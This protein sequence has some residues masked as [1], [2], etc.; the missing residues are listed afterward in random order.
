MNYKP[1]I[2]PLKS[3][4]NYCKNLLHSLTYYCAPARIVYHHLENIKIP[5]TFTT[6]RIL[7][8]LLLNFLL[9]TIINSSL[10]NPG[11]FSSGKIISSG[12]SLNVLYQMFRV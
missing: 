5:Q 3:N 2:S 6:K 4:L 11:P 8:I 12:L 7:F 10:L 9:I 1:N